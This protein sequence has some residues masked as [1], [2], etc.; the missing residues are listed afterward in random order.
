MQQFDSPPQVGS[1]TSDPLATGFVVASEPVRTALTN[2]RSELEVISLGET[3]GVREGWEDIELGLMLDHGNSLLSSVRSGQAGKAR[4]LSCPRLVWTRAA[5]M[6]LMGDAR[7]DAVVSSA[8]ELFANTGAG[9]IF[10]M[11]CG[12]EFRLHVGARRVRFVMSGACVRVLGV[13]ASA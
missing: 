5:D 8:M 6:D 9:T 2:A 4:R 1:R 10:S 12:S 7:S 13:F 11:P 3:A